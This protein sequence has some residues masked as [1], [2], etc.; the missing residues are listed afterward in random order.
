M[1][2]PIVVGVDG[3]EGSLR[4]LDWTA[5]E[6]A[7]SRLPLRV[8]HASLW[9]RHT[10]KAC[11]PP[12]TPGVRP[13]RSSPS[14]SSRPH[15]NGRNASMACG[16]WPQHGFRFA[17]R[18]TAGHSSESAHIVQSRRTG[19]HRRPGTEVPCPRPGACL[20]DPAREPGP[21]ATPR[22]LRSAYGPR[23]TRW[24][25]TS[26]RRWSACTEHGKCS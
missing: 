19:T 7:R 5:A 9:E 3:S 17:P 26:P 13:S 2:L 8:V 22:R 24:P 10:T 20:R 16:V 15:R 1:R 6:A 14:I 12:S 11:V 21:L 25:S 4:A 23:R 18:S